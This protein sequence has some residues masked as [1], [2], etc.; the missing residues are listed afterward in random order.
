MRPAHFII[1]TN[2]KEFVQSAKDWRASGT[3][4]DEETCHV[5]SHGLN[6]ISDC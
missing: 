6:D 3:N 5:I 1:T 4:V 2:Q